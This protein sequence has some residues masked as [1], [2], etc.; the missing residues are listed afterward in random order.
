MLYP[1]RKPR[2]VASA[3]NGDKI[4]MIATLRF[5]F[6]AQEF[7]DFPFFCENYVVCNVHSYKIQVRPI[8]YLSGSTTVTVTWCNSGLSPLSGETVLKNKLWNKYDK[9]LVYHINQVCCND[10]FC[11]KNKQTHEIN[12]KRHGAKL[13]CFSVVLKS[14]SLYVMDILF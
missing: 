13:I 3:D 8:R 1:Q 6:V 9:H 5:K 2:I 11:L 4:N 10:F 7:V 14:M 12:K